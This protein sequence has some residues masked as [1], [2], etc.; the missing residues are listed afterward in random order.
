MNEQEEAEAVQHE[1]AMKEIAGIVGEAMLT[2]AARN[3]S[4]GLAEIA[5]G[6]A[7]LLGAAYKLAALGGEDAKI[8]YV[9]FLRSHADAV[10]A[11][12]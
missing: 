9:H 10:E 4:F 6:T 3:G 8:A 12:L 2:A 5:E 11:R 1:R 7:T